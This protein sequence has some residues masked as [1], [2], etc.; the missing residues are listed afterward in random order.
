VL[1]TLHLAY[2]SEAADL[3]GIPT[4]IVQA[5][6]VPVAYYTGDDFKPAARRPVEEI[7][8]WDTWKEVAP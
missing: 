4:G 6:L 5:G 8:Y 2:E 3:L 7:T 1:T